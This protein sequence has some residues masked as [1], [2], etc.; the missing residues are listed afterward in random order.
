MNDWL[1]FLVDAVGGGAAFI[2]LF[3]GT[4]RLAT[5]TGARNISVVMTALGAGYCFLYGGYFLWKER[6]TRLYVDALYRTAAPKN[7]LPA[8]W[9]EHLAPARR[10]ASSLSLARET[11]LQ[12][13]TLRS[14]FDASGARKPFAPAQT[15]VRRRDRVVATQTRL[16]ENMRES[17]TFGMLW[18]V[19]GVI[20][21][22]FGMG[23]SRERAVRA[24]A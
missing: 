6:E 13:G 15:D 9:G 10:E 16:E 24:A 5:G 19:W 7:E 17:F 8:N 18:L 23:M 22:L 12:S 2:C 3:E 21:V 11:Y 20:A 4:R 14:Y 1:G